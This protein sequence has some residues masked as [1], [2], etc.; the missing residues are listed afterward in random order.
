[1]ALH[2]YDPVA[3]AALRNVPLAEVDSQDRSLALSRPWQLRPS[4]LASI[5]SHG[6]LTPLRLRPK[7]NGLMQVVH[8][9][10]RF[11][12]ARRL[13]LPSIPGLVLASRNLLKLFLQALEE[14]RT[15]RTLSSLE[16]AAALRTLKYRFNVPEKRLIEEFLPLLDLKENRRTLRLHLDLAVLPDAL[17]Q[18]LERGLENETALRLSGRPEDFQSLCC[19]LIL[20]FQLGKNRQK[21]LVEMLDEILAAASKQEVQSV[22][23]VWRELGC[24]ALE[25]RADLT[26]ADRW[27]RILAL[28]RQARY[29]ALSRHQA[30][31]DELKAALKLPP[32]VRLQAPRYFEGSSLEISMTVREARQL[33]GLARELKRIS[34]SQEW[35]ELF[36]LL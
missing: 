31:F 2:P 7:Q 12:A 30:R 14:G 34:G 29:P 21:K 28:L 4:L 20:S 26:P 22:E 23:E 24:A 32:P 15:A 3:G 6:I 35:E 18:A 9:F 5:A 1:M 19:R 16:N 33:D 27:K 8:G 10:R 13:G 36:R 11:E 17:Q 25:N